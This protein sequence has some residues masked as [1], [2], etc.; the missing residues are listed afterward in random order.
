MNTLGENRGWPPKLVSVC[1]IRADTCDRL[2]AIDS[3]TIDLATQPKQ[4]S[5]PKIM[6]FDLKSD[7]LLFSYPLKD[8]TDY[9][10]K[11]LFPTITVDVTSANCDHAFAYLPD[12]YN[13]NLVVYSMQT[14]DT[15][16]VTHNYFHF[17]PLAGDFSNSG[18]HWQWQDG[19]F[20][21]AL[22]PVDREG[23]RIV[24]FHALAS[25][26][27]F[28]I[29]SKYLQNSTL[30]RDNARAFKVLGNRGVNGQSS[31]SFLDEETGVLFYTLI[32]RNAVGC[33][34]TFKGEEYETKNL[35]VVAEDEETMTFPNDLKVDKKGT[36]WVLSTPLPEFFFSNLNS[37]NTN[38]RI[39]TAPVRQAIKGTVC[40]EI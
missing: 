8:K 3:G 13:Y 37:K 5:P 36:L 18:F 33:W 12:V 26:M 20:G 29:S 38:F 27:E 6:V 28:A 19:V 2:W 22:S 39:F 40:D 11:S 25:T 23:F 16:T 30:V 35:G 10:E 24:Y 1:R 7:Q 21:L 17:D 9:N 15:H 31:A 32:N 4:I 34:N 14:N